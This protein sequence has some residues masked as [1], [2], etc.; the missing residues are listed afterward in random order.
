MKQTIKI[1]TSF[2]LLFVVFQASAQKGTVKGKIVDAASGETIIGA[3]ISIPETTTGTRTNVQGDYNLRLPAGKHRLK[4]SFVS[5]EPQIFESV[6]VVSGKITTLN[7]QLK[8]RAKKTKMVVIRGEK[9]K[10]SEAGMLTQKRKASTVTDGASAETFKKTGDNDAAV[11]VSRV[12]G[13]SVEGGKYVYVRGLGDRYTKSQLNGVDIPGLDPDRNTV[14]MDIFPTNLLDNITIHKTFS[15]NLPGDFTGGMVDVQTKSFVRKKTIGFK[16]S[17][18]YTA[19]MNLNSKSL[20]Y[21]GGPMDY[22]GFG[23]IYRKLPIS[24]ITNLPTK[25]SSDATLTDLTRKFN[26]QLAPT[27]FTS[28]LN[29]ALAFSKGN[30]FTKG[31]SKIGFNTALNYRYQF[32][33]YD[34]FQIG[35]VIKDGD[36]GVTELL[37]DRTTLGQR[38]EQE[39]SWSALLGGAIKRKKSK[40]VAN[41]LHTQNALTRSAIYTTRFP[42][43]INTGVPLKQFVLDYSQ[44]S[45]SNLLLSGK[46]YLDNKWTVDWKLSPTY[47][48][49]VEPDVRNTTYLYEDGNYQ[50]DNGDG[51][52]PERFY[53]SL[54]ELNGVAK[55]DAKRKYQLAEDKFTTLSVGLANTIKHRDYQLL[56]FI[57]DNTMGEQWTGNGD[58]MLDDKNLWTPTNR[59]GT[60]VQTEESLDRNPNVYNAT[61]NVAAAYVMNE[62][63]LTE[64]LKAIYGVRAEKTDMWISGYGRFEGEEIDENKVDEKVMDALNILPA[65]N[66]VYQSHEKVNLR[67]SYSRT[68]ARPSFKEK[69]FVSILDPL[70][71]V[72]F[73]GNINLVNTNINNIDLRYENYFGRNEIFSASAFYKHFT[74]PIEIGSFLLEPNDVTP[75]NAGT[76]HLVGG[77]IEVRKN[78]GFLSNKLKKFSFNTNVTVVQSFID[79][80]EVVVEAGADR[81]Y[82]TSDD[83]TEYQSRTAHLRTGQKLDFYRPMFG[84]S[85]FVINT[86]LNYNNDSLGLQMQASYN[87][88]GKRIAVVGVGARPDVFDQP[89]HSLNFKASQFIGKD[90]KWKA[91]LT[92]RNIL[93]QRRQQFYESY[94]AA[95]HVFQ[96]FNPGRA[97]SMSINYLLQ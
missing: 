21:A 46:H 44:R 47:S 22:L 38:S 88:Q 39:I 15:P 48:R 94:N 24:N 51:A 1:I 53:R 5:F 95:P 42:Y 71:N 83:L 16:A 45:V 52:I 17:L 31:K 77:E 89:F 82:R 70:S 40:Y 30:Q 78:L 91:S 75:R 35:R 74:N 69:S 49:I 87:V 13:V 59:Q 41:L 64:K 96:S 97:F 6:N 72:R 4:V 85:P 60:Y 23:N 43:A 76:A 84:Q 33:H 68:L 90:R 62:Y 86:G 28:P 25:G 3:S 37:Q 26:P 92:I 57:F 50:I 54:Y 12:T 19:G 27:N 32:R 20:C 11:A 55:V 73:I 80:R 36:K 67:F 56:R 93:N 9:V 58:E 61:Q 2:L 34:D 29:G 7:I 66:L 14:Q 10:N 18:G 65:L 79:M 63:P 81:V 8:K